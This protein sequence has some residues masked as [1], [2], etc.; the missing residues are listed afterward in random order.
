MFLLHYLIPLII[1]YFY[2][3]KIVLLGLVFG[4]LIDLDHVYYR[5][6]GKIGWFES[7]CPQ[8]GMQCS[9]GFYPLHNLTFMLV[10]LVLSSLVFAKN[11][12]VKLVGWVFIGALF[13]LLLDYV[14]LI[15]GFGF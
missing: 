13:N 4:N 14:H 10:S 5:L 7:A 3:N 8:L 11:K 1:F 9:F 2:R 6:I 15:T 12:K